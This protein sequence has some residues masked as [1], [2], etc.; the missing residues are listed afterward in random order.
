MFFF[1]FSNNPKKL[2]KDEK[3]PIYTF[4]L[5]EIAM[6]ELTLDLCNIYK[7]SL[8]PKLI[9]NRAAFE[10]SFYDLNNLGSYTFL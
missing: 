8:H 5:K 10:L 4:F 7:F 6:S 3:T 2:K 9:L 1:L